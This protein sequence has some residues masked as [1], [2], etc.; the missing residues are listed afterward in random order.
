MKKILIIL[1]ILVIPSFS[2]AKEWKTISASEINSFLKTK[3]HFIRFIGDKKY[4]L[5]NVKEIRQLLN[6][7]INL[8]YIDSK[9]LDCDDLSLILHAEVR[10]Q[11]Y[12]NNNKY[13]LAFGEAVIKSIGG[14]ENHALNFFISD[15]K[16]LY[17]FDPYEFRTYKLNNVKLLLIRM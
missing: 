1:F 16:I 8:D 15:E 9:I 11:M 10:K 4:T 5:V 6:K 3:G 12:I 17:I 13:P 14:G 7:I 2:F